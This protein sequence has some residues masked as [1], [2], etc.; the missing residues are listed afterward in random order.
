MAT[1]ESGT[2]FAFLW[3]TV[4]EL[5]LDQGEAIGEITE[6][7]IEGIITPSGWDGQGRV[8]HFHLA[9]PEEMNIDLSMNSK[10]RELCRQ[11]GA[12]VRL[13]G[14]MTASVFEVKD[15]KIIKPFKGD[16]L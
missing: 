13:L 10:C 3:G 1:S 16:M 4:K 2:A 11:P 14:K 6:E 15:F 7:W 9:L 12:V 8:V 5:K